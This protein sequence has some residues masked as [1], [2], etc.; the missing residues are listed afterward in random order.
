[1]QELGRLLH[2][3]LLRW[4]IPG[5]LMLICSELIRWSQEKWKLEIIENGFKEIK[6]PMLYVSVKNVVTFL[7]T[8]VWVVTGLK[9]IAILLPPP[10]KS[11]DFGLY[12]WFGMVFLRGKFILWNFCGLSDNYY[13][14]TKTHGFQS[15]SLGKLVFFFFLPRCFTHPFCLTV[16]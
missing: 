13:K 14:K 6:I 9:F 10:P 11:W 3:K 16:P 2:R 1:M 8:L 12:T 5:S 4:L 7:F 15:A